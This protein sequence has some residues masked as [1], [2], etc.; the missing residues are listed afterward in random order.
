M[1][2]FIIGIFVIA[3]IAFIDRYWRVGLSIAPITLSAYAVAEFKEQSKAIIFYR[4]MSR[5]I[6][7]YRA[8][9]IHF[10]P[11]HDIIDI[12]IDNINVGKQ[13]SDFAFDKTIDI[14]GKQ[15]HVVLDATQIIT[16]IASIG[17]FIGDTKKEE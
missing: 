9:L 6:S 3:T 14:I 13:A 1:I 10:E 8:I 2:M 16:T 5:D 15:C 12:F 4:G 11:Q 7:V 17:S